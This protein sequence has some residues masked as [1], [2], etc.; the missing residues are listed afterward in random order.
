MTSNQAQ[1][2]L[3]LLSIIESLLGQVI[4]VSIVVMFFV[5]FIF[6]VNIGIWF[7]GM[8]RK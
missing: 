7:S 4:T 3:N 8:L 2:M 5:V 6:F 1:L